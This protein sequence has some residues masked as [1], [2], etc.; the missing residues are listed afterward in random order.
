MLRKFGSN[1]IKY[2]ELCKE[3]KPEIKQ[4]TYSFH[5]KQSFCVAIYLYT[6]TRL[7]YYYDM[8]WIIMFTKRVPLQK[9]MI[10]LSK[11]L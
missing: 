8:E 7:L 3:N 2:L 6:I 5:V 9:I 10:I 11:H 4:T 1:T